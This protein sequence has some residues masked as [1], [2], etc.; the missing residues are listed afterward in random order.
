MVFESKLKNIIASTAVI[1]YIAQPSFGT[2]SDNTNT[3]KP[4][5]G[6]VK[7]TATSQKTWGQQHPKMKAAAVG[8][9]IG[10]AAGGAT[11]LLTGRGVVRGAAI[12]AGAGAGA[13]VLRK[14]AIAKR[15]PI[16][17]DGATGLI[18]GAGL[19][20]ASGR[21]NMTTKGALIGGAAG[22]G[23]GLWKNRKNL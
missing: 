20:L 1:L 16:V 10:A 19:G 22:F 18:A 11:G 14:T 17:S 21:R 6:G 3:Q 23:V 7:K 8:G 15:H 2:T 5:S 9:G 13:G 12:G 4:L